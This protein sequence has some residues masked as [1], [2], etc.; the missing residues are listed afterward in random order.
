MPAAISCSRPRPR[1]RAH[2]RGYGAKNTQ[3]SRRGRAV[4]GRRY[5]SPGQGRFLGRDP[6]GEKGGVNIYAFT[7]NNPINAWDILGM[8]PSTLPAVTVSAGVRTETVKDGTCEFQVTYVDMSPDPAYGIPEWVEV[9]RVILTCVDDDQDRRDRCYGLRNDIAM[10]QESFTKEMNKITQYKNLE[11]R[12]NNSEGFGEA[13]LDIGYDALSALVDLS[14]WSTVGFIKDM[15]I[16]G[17]KATIEYGQNT[18]ILPQ[19]G[20]IVDGAV[21]AGGAAQFVTREL[22]SQVIGPF[23]P[24]A[25]PIGSAAIKLSGAAGLIG[26]VV[27]DKIQQRQLLNAI[28]TV[29][30]VDV[31]RNS[32]TKDHMLNMGSFMDT[33]IAA[34]CND[35]FF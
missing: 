22:G 6:K 31:W 5:Y 35:I 23:V 17:W 18:E 8:N 26:T 25:L 7:Q 9:D 27:L 13:A 32:I 24:R 3:I 2:N 4:S 12:F 20:A 29:S 14:G 19:V 33:Y 11:R 21:M 34:G 10:L 15:T 30:D 28:L 1:V 16:D